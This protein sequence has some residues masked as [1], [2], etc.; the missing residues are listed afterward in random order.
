MVIA[1]DQQQ[2]LRA[3]PGPHEKEVV[4]RERKAAN[5]IAEEADEAETVEVDGSE[6][7]A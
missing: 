6:G 5:G 1:G 4:R 3:E 2:I 7:G